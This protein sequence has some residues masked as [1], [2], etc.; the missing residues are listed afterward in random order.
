MNGYTVTVAPDDAR[1]ATAVIRYEFTGDTPRITNF[2]LVAAEGRSL[3]TAQVPAI[4]FEKLLGA[5]LPAVSVTPASPAIARSIA[6]AAVETAVAEPANARAITPA[7]ISPRVET[8]GNALRSASPKPRTRAA[9]TAPAKAT[10]T[11]AKKAPASKAT[12]RKTATPAKK[13]AAGKARKAAPPAPSTASGRN[14]MPENFVEIYRQAPTRTAIA[15]YFNVK[16]YTAQSWIK[17]ARRRG[18]IPDARKRT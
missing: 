9:R 5:V 10:A 12:P 3:S 14:T 1:E 4:D 7:A 18:L 16:D 15:D 17:T 8:D 2:S 11:P 6:P 13:T